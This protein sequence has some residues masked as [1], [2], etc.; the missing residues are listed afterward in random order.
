MEKKKENKILVD[1]DGIVCVSIGEEI[2]KSSI[3]ELLDR[4]EDVLENTSI[5]AK[6]I[7]DMGNVT[8]LRSSDFREE[9][10]ERVKKIF[11][12]HN[13][14]RAAFYSKSIVVRTVALFIVSATGLKNIKVFD[15]EEK[16]KNWL[17]ELSV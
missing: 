1:K 8:I 17:E 16:S 2:S 13:F 10:S 7:I 6:I 4:L 12:E 9:L 11:K 15:S 14:S 3:R 5:K